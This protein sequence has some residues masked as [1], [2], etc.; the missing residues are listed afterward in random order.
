MEQAVS[1]IDDP[2]AAYEA[3]ARRLSELR[4]GGRP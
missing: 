1:G 3:I 2:Q 4:A